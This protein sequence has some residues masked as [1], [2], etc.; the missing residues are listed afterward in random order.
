MGCNT[1]AAW[2]AGNR[3]TAACKA[4]SD[5]AR[6]GEGRSRA[7]LDHP[8]QNE[9]VEDQPAHDEM[10]DCHRNTAAN[11]VAA[12]TKHMPTIPTDSTVATMPASDGNA[13]LTISAASRSKGSSIAL[14]PRIGA[15]DRALEQQD[16][17]HD[18]IRGAVEPRDL[19]GRVH[20]VVAYAGREVFEDRLKP[21][22][23]FAHHARSSIWSSKS[24]IASSGVLPCP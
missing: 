5:P 22:G 16:M 10:E 6:G 9:L 21:I 3:Q 14:P 17:F 19:G 13:V 8:Q 1:A 18:L 4:C 7:S 11:G 15:H 24:T 12:I 20:R 23:M 2:C